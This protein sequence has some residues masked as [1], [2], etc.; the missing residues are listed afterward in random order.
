MTN[1]RR[2]GSNAE[3][4]AETGGQT[5]IE[6]RKSVSRSRELLSSLEALFIPIKGTNR[7]PASASELSSL[8]VRRHAPRL[9]SS[10]RPRW[11]R[12]RWSA[13]TSTPTCPKGSLAEWLTSVASTKISGRRRNPASCCEWRHPRRSYAMPVT[14]SPP[15]SHPSMPPGDDASLEDRPAGQ[16]RRHCRQRRSG[17][18]DALLGSEHDLYKTARRLDPPKTATALRIWIPSRSV[19]R[20]WRPTADLKAAGNSSAGAMGDQRV[21]TTFRPPRVWRTACPDTTRCD[22]R[23]SI[24]VK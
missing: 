5:G 13:T 11:R 9:I 2:R 19:Q 8:R 10:R 1:A 23:K 3:K 4:M 18:S 6:R 22:R 7:G 21:L 24:S 15:T 16:G 12:V 20:S 14:A 17:R